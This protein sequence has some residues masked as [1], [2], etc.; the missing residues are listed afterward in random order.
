MEKNSGMIRVK[1]MSAKIIS[2]ANVGANRINA[3]RKLVQ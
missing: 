1:M 3:K 2:L